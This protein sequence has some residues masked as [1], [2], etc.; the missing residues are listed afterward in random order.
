MLKDR[1]YSDYSPNW[2]WSTAVVAKMQTPTLMVSGVHDKQVNPMNFSDLHADIGTKQKE[3]INLSC[4]SHAAMWERGHLILFKAS[5][6][7]LSK[8]TGRRLE[9]GFTIYFGKSK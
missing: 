1:S 6:E 3:L 5:L 9:P 4:E 8:G 2:G 7:C